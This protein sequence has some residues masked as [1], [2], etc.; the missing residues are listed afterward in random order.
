MKKRIEEIGSVGAKRIVHKRKRTVGDPLSVGMVTT[1]HQASKGYRT[2]GERE[3]MALK[4]RQD[5]NK[6]L[7]GGGSSQKIKNRRLGL[8]ENNNSYNRVYSMLLEAAR[9]NP[10]LDYILKS[11]ENVM[12]GATRAF[13]KG[14]KKARTTGKGNKG[15][16]KINDMPKKFSSMLRRARRARKK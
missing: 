1:K 15:E 3:S 11:K 10:Q 5:T 9:S 14:A 4:I 8:G 16:D 2:E 12:S 6:G 13:M 7:R